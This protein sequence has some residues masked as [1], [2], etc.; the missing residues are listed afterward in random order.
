MC[1]FLTKRVFV[2]DS[3]GVGGKGRLQDAPQLLSNNPVDVTE[4]DL[5]DVVQLTADLVHS[6]ILVHQDGI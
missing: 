3:M 5:F 2:V 6:V 4:G 1:S